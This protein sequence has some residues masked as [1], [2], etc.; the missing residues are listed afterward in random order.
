[1]TPSGWKSFL[2]KLP[3]CGASSTMFA[4]GLGGKAI[5]YALNDEGI[6]SPA[7]NWKRTDRRTDGKWQA[8]AIVG[9]PKKLSV[10]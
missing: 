1:M 8:S 4:E 6:A 2:T 3:L 5:A 7:K 10:S 9:V